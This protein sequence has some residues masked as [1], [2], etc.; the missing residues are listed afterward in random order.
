MAPLIRLETCAEIR[1]LIVIPTSSFLLR[2]IASIAAA[3]E[4]LRATSPH[5]HPLP[6]VVRRLDGAPS[7]AFLAALTPTGDCRAVIPL[8]AEKNIVGRQSTCPEYDWQ[9]CNGPLVEAGQWVL[10]CRDERTAEVADGWSTNGSFLLP[11]TTL[12][13]WPEGVAVSLLCDATAFPGRLSLVHPGY[14]AQRL[15]WQPIAEGDMLVG[16]YSTFVFGWV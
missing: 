2:T 5:E 11:V 13:R 4:M 7:V 1:T 10:R 15:A 14:N 3:R 6:Y 8:R 16:C 12:D 9:T